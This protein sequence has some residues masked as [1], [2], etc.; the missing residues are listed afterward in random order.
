MNGI[1]YLLDTNIVIGLLQRDLI[2]LDILNDRQI[3]IGEC[4][5]SA[6]TPMELLSFPSITPTEKEAIVFLLSRMT[7]LTITPAIENE[8]INFRYTHKTKL[9]DSI[10]A[11]TTKYHGLEL[12]TLDKKLANKL[13]LDN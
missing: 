3:Q 13:K 10:I 5:Y 6:I 7:Y 2:I 9:P 4:A 8:T 1:K 11:A 12:I